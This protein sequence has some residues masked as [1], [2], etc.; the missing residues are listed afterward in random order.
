MNT[1]YYP[2][3]PNNNQPSTPNMTQQV[4]NPATGSYQYV[5]PNLAY[6]QNTAVNAYAYASAPNADASTANAY[7]S[8]TPYTNTNNATVAYN[9]Y[10]TVSQINATPGN[11]PSVAQAYTN[12]YAAYQAPQIPSAYGYGTPTQNN[13]TGY[14]YQYGST[15]NMYMNNARNA[16]YNAA[17]A[18]V[19]PQYANLFPNR[20]ISVQKKVKAVYCEECKISCASQSAFDDHIKGKTHKRRLE[21]LLKMK[22][23]KEGTVVK[24]R[25]NN[26]SDKYNCAVCDV[27]CNNRDSLSSHLKGNKHKRVV[28]TLIKMGKPVPPVPQLSDPVMLDNLGSSNMATKYS[29]IKKMQFVPSKENKYLKGPEGVKKLD[30][31]NLTSGL[32]PIGIE[33]IH[34][35]FTDDAKFKAWFC[36]ICNKGMTDINAN[37]WH[38]AS[39]EH[40]A[41]YKKAIDNL[42]GSDDDVK[43]KDEEKEKKPVIK[44][45]KY[46]TFEDERWS[47]MYYMWQRDP[48]LIHLV[49][50]PNTIM[51]Q[52]MYAPLKYEHFLDDA[53]FRK[54]NDIRP[55]ESELSIFYSMIMDVESAIR[56][57]SNDTFE[58]RTIKIVKRKHIP[59]AVVEAK[60]L[61]TDIDMKPEVNTEIKMEDSESI[62]IDKPDI[63]TTVEESKDSSSAVLIEEPKDVKVDVSTET[64]KTEE[65]TREVKERSIRSVDRVSF[66]SKGLLIKSDKSVDL[67]V[68]CL[69]EPTMQFLVT[70][71]Q[72]LADK[73]EENYIIELKENE[74]G[75][76][77]RKKDE[78]VLNTVSVVFTSPI[79]RK[80][81]ENGKNEFK[82]EN[83]DSTRKLNRAV[84]L[85]ALAEL[86]HSKWFQGMI[87]NYS[88]VLKVL[89]I[90]RFLIANNSAWHCVQQWPLELLMEK[91]QRTIYNAQDNVLYV[92]VGAL[93]KRVIQIVAQ[94]IFLSDEFSISDPCEINVKNTFSYLTIEERQ[95][96]TFESQK[97]LRQLTFNHNIHEIFGFEEP[98]KEEC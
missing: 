7:Q 30:K 80:M 25:Y 43:E 18:T 13:S 64:T 35:E 86:R 56:V 88:P 36:E 12:P 85:K 98:I 33:Y 77:V 31:N 67:V 93:F 14:S 82:Q 24:S 61:K 34:K 55:E 1:N 81:C 4:Y 60:T 47:K 41:T 94:G 66:L 75:F 63:N 92:T 58:T 49:K 42:Y 26:T 95:N 32:L 59:E 17:L 38:A 87:G 69:S 22:K 19:M 46:K 15:S 11:I 70:I 71:T 57:I 51:R 39:N 73:L 5:T 29:V 84:C 74:S 89:R 97:M 16:A 76:T 27:P 91:A 40:R 96:L 21:L 65:Q 53:I 90:M 28:A 68:S 45:T 78:T 48:V 23:M 62:T 79:I 83:N 54:H 20:A 3:N 6:N 2:L 9:A 37:T 52:E 50:I 8:T 72:K 44:L 10:A